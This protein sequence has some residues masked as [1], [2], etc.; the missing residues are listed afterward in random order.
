MMPFIL[1]FACA[2]SLLALAAC[3]NFDSRFADEARTGRKPDAYAGAYQGRWTSTSHPGSGGKLRCILTKK[4][5]SDY[6]A[7]FKATWH[8]AFSSE[9]SVIL[10]AKPGTSRGRDKGVLHF[11][12]RAEIRMFVG[13]GT[14]ECE[15]Q[16][17]G[18]RM[19]A[20]YD[21]TYD[22]GTFELAR[23]SAPTGR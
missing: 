20:C 9:H 15:G 18:R 16:M 13:S 23:A 1:R 17:D 12:G 6:L 10:H 5:A 2:L 14:Y 11:A 8:G 3:S 7:E 21:A 22:R 19:Q 4:G